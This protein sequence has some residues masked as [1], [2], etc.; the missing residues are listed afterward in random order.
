[1]ESKK[2][3][4]TEMKTEFAKLANVDKEIELEMIMKKDLKIGCVIMA[5]GVSKRFGENKL[6]AEFHGKSLIQRVLE[7]TDGELFEKRLVLTRTPE[8]AEICEK[9]NVLVICHNLSERREAI[10]LGV[11]AMSEVDGI[12]FCPCDQPFLS[13]ESLSRMVK[14]FREKMEEKITAVGDKT[15]EEKNSMKKDTPV[16]VQETLKKYLTKWILR[17]SCENEAGAPVLFG[18]KYFEELKNLPKHSGGSW[19]IKKY[20]ENLVKIQAV[21]KWELFDIDTK[22]DLEFLEKHEIVL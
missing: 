7:L 2:R 18:S 4:G 11:D 5:S 1:M 13:Q 15:I 10:K 22:E 14:A 20:P 9:Q 12:L 17:L 21:H 6:L 19:L 3:T 16:R 8:V